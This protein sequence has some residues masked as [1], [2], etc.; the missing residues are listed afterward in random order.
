MK[1]VALD[2]HGGGINALFMDGSAKKVRVRRLW[3][4]LWHKGYPRR[5]ADEMDPTFWP[6]W[7]VKMSQ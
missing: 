5:R 3:N 7:I 1:H 4:L 2:R 6:D